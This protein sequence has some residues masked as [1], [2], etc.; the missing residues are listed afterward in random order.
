M[1]MSAGLRAFF[2]SIEVI[3]AAKRGFDEAPSSETVIG[4]AS[5]PLF[6]VKCWYKKD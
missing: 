3:A 6:W 2:A 1:E 5:W 4:V